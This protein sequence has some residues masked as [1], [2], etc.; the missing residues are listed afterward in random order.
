MADRGI[1]IGRSDSNSGSPGEDST[2]VQHLFKSLGRVIICSKK[3][4]SL[5]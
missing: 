1:I 4:S 5:I 2:L 3:I